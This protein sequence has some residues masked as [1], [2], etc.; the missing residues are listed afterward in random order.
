MKGG[1]ERIFSLTRSR[2]QALKKKLES[3]R[4][5]TKIRPGPELGVL[6]SPFLKGD[7]RG[8]FPLK[9]AGNS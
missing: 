8:I 3:G 1:S 6:T 4:K 5:L 9:P 2:L 7:K